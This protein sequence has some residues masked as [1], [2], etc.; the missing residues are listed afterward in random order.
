MPRIVGQKTISSKDL[1]DTPFVLIVCHIL[2]SLSLVLH[3]VTTVLFSYRSTSAHVSMT[4]IHFTNRNSI[5]IQDRFI[6]RNCN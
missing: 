3:N 2:D 4:R 5:K 6:V 1:L